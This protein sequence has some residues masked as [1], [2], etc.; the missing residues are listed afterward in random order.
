[1]HTAEHARFAAEYATQH[2]LQP[3]ALN[4]YILV[5][6]RHRAPTAA[7]ANTASSL[8]RA[9]SSSMR[10]TGSSSV[11]SARTTSSANT[12]T[13]PSRNRSAAA[14]LSTTTGRSSS[15]VSSSPYTVR[16]Q[17][18]PRA[19]LLH[20]FAEHHLRIGVSATPRDREV[21]SQGIIALSR[22]CRFV[23][24][25]PPLTMLIRFIIEYIIES[26][27]HTDSFSFLSGLL[28]S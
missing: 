1:M 3:T 25:P 16:F 11:T 4:Y 15:N 6:L 17:D 28:F 27:T 9:R 2:L 8:V 7:S 12:A 5:F 21:Y 19:Y 13:S 18:Q 10:F 24:L 23:L 22:T 26:S 20:I 14:E